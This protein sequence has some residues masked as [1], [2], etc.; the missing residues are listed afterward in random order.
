MP[1][2]E[3]ESRS[4]Q[5]SIVTSES[6][7]PVVLPKPFG[8]PEK[9]MALTF[10]TELLTLPFNDSAPPTLLGAVFA[11]TCLSLPSMLAAW[12]CI[13]SG[14]WRYCLTVLLA[15][16]NGFVLTWTSNPRFE[17]LLV[18]LPLATI[19]PTLLTLSL[20]KRVFGRFGPLASDAEF[21]VEGLRFNLSH[22]FIAVSYTHLT[23]PTILLV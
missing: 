12:S 21:F 8:A 18:L 9:L 10:A 5:L 23:L 19:L 1:D 11:G 7:K 2:S 17:L 20:I 3:M 15:L 6:T 14:A 13:R 22:L 16:L 4:E